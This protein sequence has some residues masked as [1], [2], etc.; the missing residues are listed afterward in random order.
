MTMI[1]NSSTWAAH[2]VHPKLD[3][4]RVHLEL[5][6]MTVQVNSMPYPQQMNLSDGVSATEPPFPGPGVVLI[7]G[8]RTP[9]PNSVNYA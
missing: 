8:W 9:T 5:R 3:F 1:L 2:F 7:R 6:S 4:P